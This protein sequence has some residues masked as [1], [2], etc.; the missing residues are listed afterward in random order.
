MS[1]DNTTYDELE[2]NLPIL[3]ELIA[4]QKRFNAG[5]DDQELRNFDEFH[6]IITRNIEQFMGRKL[7]I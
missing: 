6:D 3:S 2:Q 7:S 4:D 1:N 5:K